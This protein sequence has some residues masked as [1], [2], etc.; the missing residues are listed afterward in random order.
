MAAL[1]HVS[2]THTSPHPSHLRSKAQRIPSKRA[3]PQSR[4][5]QAPHKEKQHTMNSST[6]DSVQVPN[7]ASNKEHSSRQTS[8]DPPPVV[9]PPPSSATAPPAWQGG[10]SPTR[11]VAVGGEPP[12][13]R[14][15]PPSQRA[16]RV[17]G[18][19]EQRRSGH[20]RRR[21]AWC[22]PRGCGRRVERHPPARQAP[23]AAVARGPVANGCDKERRLPQPPTWPPAACSQLTGGA[24]ARHIPPARAPTR[25]TSPTSWL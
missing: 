25:S 21:T 23:V 16:R 22:A 14:P 5:R 20:R 3:T 1:S 7:C 17:H 13:R 8:K 10:G 4:E 15:R 6:T 19:S 24:E 2:H 18:R 9:L 11:A 12:P